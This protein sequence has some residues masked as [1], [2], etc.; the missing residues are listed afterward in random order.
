MHRIQ[1]TDRDHDRMQKL[2]GE[3]SRIIAAQSDNNVRASDIDALIVQTLSDA[4]EKQVADK[5]DEHRSEFTF[6]ED[7]YVPGH[8]DCATKVTLCNLR[9]CSIISEDLLSGDNNQTNLL[10]IIFV[11]VR[12]DR[13]VC[14]DNNKE[15]CWWCALD[16]YILE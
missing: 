13:F 9:S 16:Q 4:G 15:N 5:W 6:W 2:S 10:P 3:R 7:T 11:T 14:R 1:E 8:I 12:E